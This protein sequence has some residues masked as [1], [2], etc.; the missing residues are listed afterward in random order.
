MLFEEYEVFYTVLS[1]LVENGYIS[2]PFARFMSKMFNRYTKNAKFA[3]NVDYA[4]ILYEI[5]QKAKNLVIEFNNATNPA[6]NLL[7]AKI[8]YIFT[9][10]FDFSLL[11]IQDDEILNIWSI[12]LIES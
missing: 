3:T 9:D 11:N 12:T 8:Y 5:C 7:C 6:Y 4:H 1:D 10:H 2:T